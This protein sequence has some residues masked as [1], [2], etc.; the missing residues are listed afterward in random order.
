V[1]NRN[2]ILSIILIGMCY[3][4]SEKI[5]IDEPRPEITVIMGLSG[6]GDNGYNDEILSGLMEVNETS[7]LSLS[8]ISPASIEEARTAL[9]VWLDRDLSGVRALLVLAGNEY[10]SLIQDVTLPND[11]SIL[12]FES[13]SKNLPN[14]VSSFIIRR[15]GISYLAGCM[16]NEAQS[17]SVIA[18]MHS[19]NYMA[20]AINGFVD[21]FSVSGKKT[22]VVYLAEDA[23][24]YGM[25]NEGYRIVKELPYNTFIYPLA[26]G[27]NSGMYKATREEEFNM[28]LIAGIDVDCYSYSTRV[29]FSVIFNIRRV[30]HFLLDEWIGGNE[31]QNHYS[32]DLSDDDIVYIAFSESFFDNLV[33]WDHYYSDPYY[34]PQRFERYREIAIEMEE[35]F[36]ENRQ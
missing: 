8:M 15:Y 5:A 22:N 29:P 24:G 36:Y 26:G 34:W 35:K 31:L 17:A 25:P 23:S 13:E 19:E 16:A 1:R 4:C 9:N 18:A 28:K 21:G 2:V 32:F 27:S 12:L 14:K 7:E 3:A 30:V 33:A 20:D 10:E 6:A 11:K